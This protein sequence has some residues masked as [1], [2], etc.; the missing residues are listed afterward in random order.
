ML[1]AKTKQFPKLTKPKFGK[2]IQKIFLFSETVKTAETIRNYPKLSETAE[3]NLKLPSI[4][5]DTKTFKSKITKLAKF[6]LNKN[7]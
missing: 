5:M 2:T 1:L 4:Q 6:K 7:L 3:T